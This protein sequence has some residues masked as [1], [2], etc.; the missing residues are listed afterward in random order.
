[1]VLDHLHTHNLTARP[2]KCRFGY[3]SI[4]YLGFI[5]DGNFL[6]TQHSKIKAILNL[7][8]PTTRKTL[9]SFLGMVS[10]Y[11][12]FIL[13]AASLTS[14]LLDLLRKGVREPLSLAIIFSITRFRYYL[15]GQ[16]F[17]L[18]YHKPLIYMNNFKGAKNWFLRWSLC[19]QSYRFIVVHV[20][21]HDNIGA[22]LPCCAVG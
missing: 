13:Q 11:R 21:G 8:P 1:M 22:D 18:V 9:Q 15:M 2:S 4:N 16:E 6:H 17:I 19:L 14:A 3:K 10:Y 20:A 12:M 5:V 7:P